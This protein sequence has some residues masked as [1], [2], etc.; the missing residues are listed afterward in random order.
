[1]YCILILKKWAAWIWIRQKI[2]ETD[3]GKKLINCILKF[4]CRAGVGSYPVLLRPYPW[5]FKDHSWWGSGD[6]M[7]YLVSNPGQPYVK[8]APYPL[9][10]W[11]NH[12]FFRFNDPVECYL[13]L[14]F[15][16]LPSCSY[17]LKYVINFIQTIEKW[18]SR[19]MLLVQ[20]LSL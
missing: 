12:K 5:L 9:Y 11:S 13:W 2:L 17:S 10:Y 19:N 15:V 8:Q 4:F 6:Q 16:I 18:V 3:M 14:V 7:R 20:S 1:M